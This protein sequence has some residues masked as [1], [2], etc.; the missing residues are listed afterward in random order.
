M[1]I[2]RSL[3]QKRLLQVHM[4]DKYYSVSRL[5]VLVPHQQTIRIDHSMKNKTLNSVMDSMIFDDP[6]L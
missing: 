5:L 6:P 4:P 1:S 3:A 2:D